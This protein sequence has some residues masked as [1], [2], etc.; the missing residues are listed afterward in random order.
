MSICIQKSEILFRQGHLFFHFLFL[1]DSAL[2]DIFEKECRNI[3]SPIYIH[4]FPP[5]FE[6]FGEGI[7]SRHLH[8]EML[9]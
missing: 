9:S 8:D 5:R 4:T 3:G 1:P 6:Y 7:S 2:N